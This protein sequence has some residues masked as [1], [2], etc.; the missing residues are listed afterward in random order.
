MAPAFEPVEAVDVKATRAR[1][2]TGLI[3]TARGIKAKGF[4][5]TSA[6]GKVSR[7]V[8]VRA[9]RST[10][11]NVLV[12]LF[13]TRARLRKLS[14]ATD[15][16]ADATQPGGVVAE[17]E[18]RAPVQRDGVI[19]PPAAMG[20]SFKLTR[21]MSFDCWL[22]TT[23]TPVAMLIATEDGVEPTAA[24]MGGPGTD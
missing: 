11:A 23:A 8:T 24:E 6:E 7:A 10:T 9:F 14:T 18:P 3:P 22:A 17:P 12:P 2:V 19:M 20:P 15:T 16:G 1:P 5:E 13:A 21:V 4:P